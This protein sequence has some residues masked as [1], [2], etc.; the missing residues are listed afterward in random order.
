MG[1]NY[2]LDPV[3]GGSADPMQRVWQ[4]F[5][6]LETRMMA[7]GVK[8]EI[9]VQPFNCSSAGSPI[10]TTFTYSWAGGRLYLVVGG[11]ATSNAGFAGGLSV[12]LNSSDLFMNVSTSPGAASGNPPL[13]LNTR[14]V[15]PPPVV[16]YPVPVIGN[17]TFSFSSAGF[18][19]TTAWFIAGLLIEWP[20]E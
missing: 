13:H 12:L 7:Q 3:S 20:F 5:A 16:G 19:N 1:S 17:N 14:V 8:R 10:P 2:L 11:W 9:V 4:K 15:S 6:D 18:P